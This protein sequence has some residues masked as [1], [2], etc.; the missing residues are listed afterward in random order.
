MIATWCERIHTISFPA[1]EGSRIS[2]VAMGHVKGM[3]IYELSSSLS[4]DF[5]EL[6][7]AEHWAWP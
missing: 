2:C 5:A 3:R 7:R 1:S 6:L 4:V